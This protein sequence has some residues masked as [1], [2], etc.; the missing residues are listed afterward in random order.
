MFSVKFMLRSALFLLPLSIITGPFLPDLIITLSSIFFIF[1][2]VLKK[3]YKYFLDKKI[4]YFYIFYFYLILSSIQSSDFLFSL[5]SSLPYIRFGFFCILVKFIS[6]EDPL[7]FKKYKL[8]VL[9]PFLYVIFDAIIQTIFG[10]NTLF[11]KV[12]PSQITGIFDDEKILGSYVSRI[13][14]IVFA[15]TIFY[16]KS[17]FKT[18]IFLIFLAMISFI[19]ILLSG[20][21]VAL[22]NFFTFIFL[23]MIF[24]IFNL[25]KLFLINL[26]ALLSIFVLILNI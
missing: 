8:Y 14:P 20:E 10:Y 18:N 16:K 15:L 3:N 13:L 26:S 4:I 19:V 2:A 5:E 17:N 9:I 7:F 23:I 21:R 6:D 22:I 24:N 1:Y 25:R 12:N 11:Y